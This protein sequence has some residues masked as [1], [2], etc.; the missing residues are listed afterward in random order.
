MLE[1][2]LE[3]HRGR[4]VPRNG[5]QQHGGHA[6]QV[7]AEDVR[8]DLVADDEAFPHAHA[9]EAL[10]AQV[11]ERRG[12][13]GERDVRQR[14][15]RRKRRHALFVVVRN[16]DEPQAGRGHPLRPFEH[17]FVRR[18]GAVR[19]HR[20]VHI[21]HQRADVHRPE[22]LGRD[23]GHAVQRAGR[24]EHG[25]A[26]H[27]PLFTKFGPG[28]KSLP[29]AAPALPAKTRF[30]QKSGRLRPASSRFIICTCACELLRTSSCA[31]RR[32]SHKPLSCA[33]P[34]SRPL[35]RTAS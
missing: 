13:A 11:A 28:R 21:E 33:L 23:V 4:R 26:G 5:V 17:A 6:A 1:P 34:E 19:R 31:L 3:P 15:L 8:E 12:L 18:L 16:D 35:W 22:Q 10:C 27:R 20:I 29:P 9:G 24:S 7:R 32:A 25:H 30:T 14:K 2:A